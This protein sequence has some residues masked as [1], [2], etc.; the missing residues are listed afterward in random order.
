MT[1]TQR[2]RKVES[3]NPKRKTLYRV[4]ELDVD[5]GTAVL[6]RVEKENIDGGFAGYDTH[7]IIHAVEETRYTKSSYKLKAHTN[8]RYHAWTATV[9]ADDEMDIGTCNEE[10]IPAP[11]IDKAAYKYLVT[12]SNI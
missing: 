12:Y 3:T 8:T 4:K 2:G 1:G 9:R 7:F 5:E 10:D 6:Y 11:S